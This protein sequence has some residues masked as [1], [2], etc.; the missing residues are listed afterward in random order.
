MISDF[1]YLGEG[2]G[3]RPSHYNQIMKDPQG[4]NW[5]EFL[6]EN[7]M[8]IPKHGQG[9]LLEMLEDIRSEF[10]IVFH[11]VSLNIGQAKGV[12]HKFLNEL[13]SF[14]DKFNPLWV[15]DHLCWTGAHGRNAHELLPLP[16]TEEAVG[17]VSDNIK[18]IQ[19][20]LQRP[21]LFE[22][23]SSYVS[24]HQSTMSEWDFINKILDKSD[25][26]LLLDLNNVY[27]SSENHDY[28]PYDFLNALDLSRVGQIHLAGHERRSNGLVV[29]T[30][31]RAVCDEVWELLKIILSERPDI[32]VM[33][34]WDAEIPT[35]DALVAELEKVKEIRHEA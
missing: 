18:R 10:P 15:S 31:S 16:Y 23:T 13:K 32:S 2:L 5:F 6:T 4:V 25:A 9:P 14:S 29:D 27:V 26:G 30:H 24:Y 7:Y 17:V 33:V 28:S 22:N 1:R 20:I 19:D 35:Y 3:F 8:G 21:F 34:E 11:C 12:D